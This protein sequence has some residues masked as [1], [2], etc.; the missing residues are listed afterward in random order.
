MNISPGIKAPF[1]VLLYRVFFGAGAFYLG[2]FVWRER[3]IGSLE[4]LFILSG[5]AGYSLLGC[6]YTWIR[7]PRSRWVLAWLG[8]LIPAVAYVGLCCMIFSQPE[9]WWDWLLCG[10]MTATV[11]ALPVTFAVFLFRDKKTNEYFTKS[12]A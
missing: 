1:A 11:F 2:W 4:G 9:A 8:I 3:H 7:S 6:F 12:A 10:L 5:F